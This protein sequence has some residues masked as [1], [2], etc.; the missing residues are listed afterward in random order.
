MPRRMAALPQEGGRAAGGA[1]PRACYAGHPSWL[2]DVQ[3][4]ACANRSKQKAVPQA[5]NFSAATD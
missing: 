3:D 5:P 1:T 2:S 4:E